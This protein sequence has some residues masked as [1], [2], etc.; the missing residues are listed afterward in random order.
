MEDVFPFAR[1]N[2]Y[3]LE[4]PFWIAPCQVHNFFVLLK[5]KIYNNKICDKD[6]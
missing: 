4:G 6:Y 3:Y 1:Y 5:T 2:F